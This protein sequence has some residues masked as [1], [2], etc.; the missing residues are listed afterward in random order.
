MYLYKDWA[1]IIPM[2]NEEDDFHPFTDL[3]AKM[4]DTLGTGKVYFIIDN[5]SKDQTLDLGLILLLIA[6]VHCTITSKCVWS[7]S[8]FTVL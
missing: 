2:A 4:M 6:F 3:L 8:E 5:V 1:A 7:S